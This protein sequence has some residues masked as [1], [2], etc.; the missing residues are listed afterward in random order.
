MSSKFFRFSFPI[1]IYS[2]FC[3]SA[4]LFIIFSGWCGLEEHIKKMRSRVLS[5]AATGRIMQRKGCYSSLV[6]LNTPQWM[7]I[8]ELSLLHKSSQSV[9]RI[10]RTEQTPYS[11]S[12]GAHLIFNA[13]GGTRRNYRTGMRS[14]SHAPPT[15]ASATVRQLSA[16]FCMLQLICT[17]SE[18][19]G[20]GRRLCSHCPRQQHSTSFTLSNV[21]SHCSPKSPENWTHGRGRPKASPVRRR[22]CRG[23]QVNPVGKESGPTASWQRQPSWVSV[24]ID[25][26]VFDVRRRWPSNGMSRDCNLVWG[27]FADWR[28]LHGR[29]IFAKDVAVAG[30]LLFSSS[31]Q[32][33]AAHSDTVGRAEIVAVSGTTAQCTPSPRD[34]HNACWM[35]TFVGRHWLASC[36]TCITTA[37]VTP[38]MRPFRSFCCCCCCSDCIV[39]NDFSSRWRRWLLLASHI[40][41]ILSFGKVDVQPY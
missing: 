2:S 8:T 32:L 28:R 39:D 21:V 12:A 10:F 20:V 18:W 22:H 38:V 19:F 11:A 23:L 35:R 33:R 29:A 24:V 30:S 16:T 15:T 41:F 37:P 31:Y 5:I 26:S 27:C 1:F 6:V 40:T 36:R 4:S 25:W 3:F 7:R 13:N 14:Q 34:C 17:Y 9:S